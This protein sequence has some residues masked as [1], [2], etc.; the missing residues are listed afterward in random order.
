MSLWCE[1]QSVQI[2]DTHPPAAGWHVTGWAEQAG[3]GVRRVCDESPVSQSN[4]ESQT[5][6]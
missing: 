4:T 5:Y 3:G 1:Q 6:R 2:Y